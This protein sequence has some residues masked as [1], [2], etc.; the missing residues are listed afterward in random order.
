[1]ANEW[2]KGTGTD[3]LEG[4]TLAAD[5]DDNVTAYIQD[6]LNRL[7][8]NYRKRCFVEYASASTVTISIGEV[9]CT[10]SGGTV[11]R[12]RQNT[13]SDGAITLDI[14]ADLDT[15]SE[16][17]T[18]WYYVYAVA[19]ADATTF[20]GIISIS[21]TFPTGV[22]YAKL[23][24]KF[25]NNSDGDITEVQDL[26]EGQIKFGNWDSKDED[27]IYQ[28]ATDGLVVGSVGGVEQPKFKV[29]SDGTATPDTERWIQAL[30]QQGGL[31]DATCCVPIKA[32]DYWEFS[33]EQGTMN[34]LYWM[35]MEVQTS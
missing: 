3:A 23:L 24:G 8:A 9:T 16:T 33:L 5:I 15:G 10:D 28:A 14:T 29:Y 22:S 20:T 17:V 32:G 21:S 13:A 34:F 35:P 25:Y 19:D 11:H 7:L 12:M 26:Y 18:T 4:S 1:M 27:T 31:G 6:P 2:M 30:D